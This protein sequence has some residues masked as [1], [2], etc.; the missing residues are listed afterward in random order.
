MFKTAY[1]IY[2][3]HAA[4][5]HMGWFGS[6]VLQLTDYVNVFQSF[7]RL[8]TN[9][10]YVLLIMTIISASINLFYFLGEVCLCALNTSSTM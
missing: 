10:V 6:F 7:R 2:H 5:T 1:E 9:T 8:V 3:L 4:L